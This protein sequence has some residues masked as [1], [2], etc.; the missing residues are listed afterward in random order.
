M[1]NELDRITIGTIIGGLV[2]ES[3]SD[4]AKIATNGSGI[5]P[6]MLAVETTAR[7]L[8]LEKGFTNS[9]IQYLVEKNRE[10]GYEKQEDWIE[11]ALRI[12]PWATNR[13]QGMLFQPTMKDGSFEQVIKIFEITGEKLSEDDVAHLVAKV[14]HDADSWEKL[15]STVE[16]ERPDLLAQVKET[17]ERDALGLEDDIPF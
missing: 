8:K 11:Q 9:A 16:A 4:F 10:M 17:L 15:L 14:R 1:S 5:N 13:F 6:M 7:R 2:L 12:A 3:V